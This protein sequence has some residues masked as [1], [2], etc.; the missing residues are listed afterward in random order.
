MK[1]KTI[2]ITKILLPTMGQELSKLPVPVIEGYRHIRT[3]KVKIK[4]KEGKQYFDEFHY[5]PKD[6]NIHPN[7]ETAIKVGN[8]IIYIE[9]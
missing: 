9:E 6:M 5:I 4:F 3:V 8:I 2:E 7:D 1:L